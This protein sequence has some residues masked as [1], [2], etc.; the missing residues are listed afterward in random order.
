MS[1][2][3]T[4]LATS[5]TRASVKAPRQPVVPTRIDGFKTRAI[6]TGSFSSSGARP[7]SMNQ[8]GSTAKGRWSFASSGRSRWTSPV[9]SMRATVGPSTAAGTPSRIELAPELAGDADGRGAGP[10]EQDTLAGQAAL[11]TSGGEHPGDDHGAGA[12]DVVV[13]AREAVAVALQDAEGVVLLEVLPLHDGGGIDASDR[14]D[15]RLEHLVIRRAAQARGAVAQVQRIVE[16]F[17]AVGP[18][19]EGDG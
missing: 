2:R 15:E 16:G 9:W 18:D 8:R 7:A 14:L 11:L 13:E 3:S 10:Q 12:L 17:L 6:A 5:R 1:G 19:V 4:W